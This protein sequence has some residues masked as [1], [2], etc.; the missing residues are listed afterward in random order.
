[1]DDHRVA[2][3]LWL[4]RKINS[5]CPAIQLIRST[6]SITISCISTTLCQGPG[7]VWTVD[8]STTHW[9]DG[10]LA[11]GNNE[12]A[13]VDALPYSLASSTHTQTHTKHFN[14]SLALAGAP[15]ACCPTPQT[16][17]R[18]AIVGY[19]YYWQKII[20]STGI[21][22]HYPVVGGSLYKRTVWHLTDGPSGTKNRR[23][24]PPSRGPCS[25]WSCRDLRLVGVELST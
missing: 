15:G 19:F 13:L 9:L 16:G 23:A 21:A 25:G 11:S 17:T 3:G 22:N 1:M 6:S 20:Y 4:R 12:M 14:N 18:I 7:R 24:Q 10:L 5:K 8:I 2:N